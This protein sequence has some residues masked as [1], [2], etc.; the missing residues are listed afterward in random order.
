MVKN[1]FFCYLTK[2]YYVPVPPSSTL[3]LQTSIILHSATSRETV[4]IDND[5]IILWKTLKQAFSNTG[6]FPNTV[7]LQYPIEDT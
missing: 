5:L 7:L 1:T 3:I 6:T 4:I 2:E